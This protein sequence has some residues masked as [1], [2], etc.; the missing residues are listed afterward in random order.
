MVST[1]SMR[2]LV[3]NVCMMVTE[4]FSDIG[5]DVLIQLIKNYVEAHYAENIYLKTVA[6]ET[7]LSYA[8]ISHYFSEKQ[9]MG[10]ADY[11]NSVRIEK[12][13]ELLKDWKIPLKE[14][15]ESVGFGSMNTFV[16]NMKKFR[17]MT[18]DAYRKANSDI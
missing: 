1:A 17:G 3:C 11:L 14:I 13:C 12:A 10:F 2:S 6:E 8:Y 18:P 9:G 7:G 15:G 4:L 16:R 5:E